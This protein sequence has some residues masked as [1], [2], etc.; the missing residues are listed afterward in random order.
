MH[1]TSTVPAVGGLSSVSHLLSLTEHDVKQIIY[2]EL[3]R[4][5]ISKYMQV[6]YSA[7]YL[8]GLK[9][10]VASVLCRAHTISSNHY[11][12]S[13]GSKDLLQP[14]LRATLASAFHTLIEYAIFAHSV[15]G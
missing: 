4:A 10:H 2:L 6:I 7:L 5:T 11:L 1:I 13:L 8:S 12:D 9:L 3:S 14:T 15:Q